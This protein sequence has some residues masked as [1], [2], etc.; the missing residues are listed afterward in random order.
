[1]TPDK[2]GIMDAP[3]LPPSSDGDDAGA[4]EEGPDP[5][6]SA[7]SDI[8]EAVKSGDVAGLKDALE[9]FVRAVMADD[10]AAPLP[11]GSDSAG[12]GY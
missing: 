9:D 6:D 7:V 5:K 10:S 4:D 1:M 12:T 2:G 11:G 8:I 3:D